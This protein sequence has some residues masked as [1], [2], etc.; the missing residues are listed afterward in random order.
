MTKIIL[1]ESGKLPQFINSVVLNSDDPLAFGD[2]PNGQVFVVPSETPAYGGQLWDGQAASDP[3]VEPKPIPRRLIRKS[4]VQERAHTLGK[5]ASIL[6][7]LRSPGQEI[8]YARWFAPDWPNVYADDAGML[9]I[10]AA[11]GCKPEEIA[12]ITERGQ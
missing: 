2:N 12:E 4:V 11:V 5:L 3:Y 6:T 10:L 1:V 9:V 8:S 7:V